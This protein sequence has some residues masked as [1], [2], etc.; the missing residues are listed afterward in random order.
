M[1]DRQPSGWYCDPIESYL[2]GPARCSCLTQP[3]PCMTIATS[4][5]GLKKPG[6]ATG[7][8]RACPHGICRTCAGSV[9]G[10]HS[11][12]ATPI[13]CFAATRRR[14]PDMSSKAWYATFLPADNVEVSGPHALESLM[15]RSLSCLR[16]TLSCR[17]TLADW[18]AT[19]EHWKD[20]NRQRLR[21]KMAE[22]V[23][24]RSWKRSGSALT[25]Y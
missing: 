10:V 22:E 16:V 13:A 14:A 2:P 6:R 15:S 19:D 18:A 3:R 24:D 1:V 5:S 21:K 7:Q 25:G 9:A 8:R 20:R 11:P 12:Q 17:K 4:G 23:V